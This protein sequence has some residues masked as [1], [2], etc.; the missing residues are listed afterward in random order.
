MNSKKG[1][2]SRRGC[3]RLGGFDAER[4]DGVQVKKRSASKM[5]LRS[6]S[7]LM[8]DGRACMASEQNE[9]SFYTS[10]TMYRK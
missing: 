8:R 4:A 6:A 9:D 3:A 2:K 10:M 7:S 1:G 5:N